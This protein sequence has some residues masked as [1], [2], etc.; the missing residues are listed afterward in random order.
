MM[1]AMNWALAVLSVAASAL[2]I[3]DV[4]LWRR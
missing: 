2:I 4:I 1:D 3:I